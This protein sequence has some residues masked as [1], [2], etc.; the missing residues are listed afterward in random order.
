MI[1]RMGVGHNGCMPHGES[2][3]LCPQLEKKVW[4]VAQGM[5]WTSAKL[6]MNLSLPVTFFNRLYI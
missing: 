1:L 4:L 2:S 5:C 6:K 3:F